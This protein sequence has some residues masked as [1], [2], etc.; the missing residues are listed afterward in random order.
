VVSLQSAS[1]VPHRRRARGV[2]GR[3]RGLL[4]PSSFSPRF[5]Q[6]FVFGERG[7]VAGEAGGVGATRAAGFCAGGPSAS[8]ADKPARLN[9][10]E[11]EIVGTEL[12]D[13]DIATRYIARTT[14]PDG[15]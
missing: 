10:Q 15:W 8:L 4:L 2:S 11:W 13:V 5:G 3:S 12:C 1:K 14:A 7:T 6:L 9:G